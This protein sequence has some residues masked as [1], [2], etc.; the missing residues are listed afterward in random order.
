MLVKDSWFKY[1][2]VNLTAEYNIFCF[3]HAGA[4]ASAYAKLGKQVAE[5][6]SFYPIQY[7]MRENRLKVKMPCSIDDLAKQIANENMELFCS[8][9]SLFYGHCYGAVVAYETA[10]YLKERYG[11]SPEILIAASAESPRISE[12][13]VRLEEADND[14][15][16]EFFISFGYMDPESVKNKVYMDFFMPILKNDYILLQ[17]YAPKDGRKIASPILAPYSPEDSGIRRAEVEKWN[18][19]TEKT[20]AVQEISGGHFFL[21]DTNFGELIEEA[22][23]LIK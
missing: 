13:T 18:E 4:G 23:G 11:Y 1:E 20:L 21:N 17:K 6:F 3:P 8:K 2:T 19:F 14:Q 9:P 12:D 10:V 15:V 16:A 5:R 22:E 7:P